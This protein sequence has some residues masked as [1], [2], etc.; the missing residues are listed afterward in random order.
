MVNSTEPKN[1]TNKLHALESS[2]RY[3][4]L[5]LKRQLKFRAPN[6]LKTRILAL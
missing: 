6:S 3:V 2:G 5:E 4:F 1:C